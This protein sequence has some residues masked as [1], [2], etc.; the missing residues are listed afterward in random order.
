MAKRKVP[1]PADMPAEVDFKGGRRGK[2]AERY[3][4]HGVVYPTSALDHV[5]R[6]YGT[7]TAHDFKSPT[8]VTVIVEGDGVFIFTHAFYRREAQ[9]EYVVIYT[10]HLGYWV[11]RRDEVVFVN[12][13][14]RA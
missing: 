5:P 1:E 12:G 8:P 11:F 13:M 2:Y 7:L 3:R 10:E 4:G 9:Q 14:R 6:L